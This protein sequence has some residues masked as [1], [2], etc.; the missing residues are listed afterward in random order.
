MP[1][2]EYTCPTCHHE[3][4][5]VVY[6]G[7]TPGKASCPKCHNEDVPPDKKFSGLF[8]GLSSFG[9]LARDTN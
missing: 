6:Q 3:F 1:T 4:K 7:D 8:T 2:I 9:G 5:R